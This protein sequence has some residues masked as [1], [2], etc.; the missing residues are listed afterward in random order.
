MVYGKLLNGNLIK[1]YFRVI[2]IVIE[3]GSWFTVRSSGWSFE[4][5]CFAVQVKIS[6]GEKG[7]CCRK[8][9]GWS[10]SLRSRGLLTFEGAGF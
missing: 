5:D 10:R 4:E 8:K 1:F 9:G 3:D 6:P 2:I 7:C